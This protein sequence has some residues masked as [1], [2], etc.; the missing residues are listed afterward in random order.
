MRRAVVAQT[1]DT[2]ARQG[3]VRRC[4]T[5][6]ADDDATELEDDGDLVR[7]RQVHHVGR[8]RA[9]ERVGKSLLLGSSEP[10]RDGAVD[11]AVDLLP[12][13]ATV[14]RVDERV[15]RV[16]DPEREGNRLADG[17]KIGRASCRER[18]FSSV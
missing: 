17:V 15:R 11:D 3:C 14:M 10:V 13:S 2:A 7:I 4:A 8:L 6:A 16:C 5:A 12:G 9:A 1:D 18:V